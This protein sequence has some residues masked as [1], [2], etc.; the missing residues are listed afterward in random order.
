MEKLP[1]LIINQG[2]STNY[3]LPVPVDNENQEIFI[4]T[5]EKGKR[6]LP[7]FMKYE[8]RTRTYQINASEQTNP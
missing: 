6:S 7:K 8:A 2:K 5:N 1:N 4:L 3:T